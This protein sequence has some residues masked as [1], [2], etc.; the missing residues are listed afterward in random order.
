VDVD[1]TTGDAKLVEETLNGERE[2]FGVLVRRYQ[3]ATY[4][5]AL[6]RV[7]NAAGAE[8]IAQDVFVTAYR[9]LD[10]LKDTSRFAAWLRSIALRR[11]AMWLRREGRKPRPSGSLQDMKAT[12]DASK[13]DEAAFSI[14]ALIAGL[15]EGLRAAAVLCMEDD[16]SP[17]AAAAVLG[18][19]P[20]TLRKRLHDARARLQRRVLEKAKRELLLHLLP[21]D[22]AERCVC[23]C[24]ESQEAKSRREVIA[25]SEKKE[26]DCGCLESSKRRVKTTSKTKRKKK[27]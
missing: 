25:M 5:L 16:L 4:A 6:Q 1:N 13:R 19:K 21:R 26:C 17:S 15:P 20:G 18:L 2:A 10:Q 24:E 7:G 11:C 8:E 12:D 14:D 23:R 3:S 22:F 27:R 9:K